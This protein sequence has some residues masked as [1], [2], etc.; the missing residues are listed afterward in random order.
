M[1]TTAEPNGT[2]SHLWALKVLSGVH[3]GAEA[4][5]ADEEATIGTDD[6]CDLILEESEV[7]ESHIRLAVSKDGVRLQLLNAHR[8]VY[9]DGQPIEDAI[10]VQ[11]F[12]VISMGVSSFALGPAGETWPQLAAAVAN[13]TA[14]HPP[15]QSTQETTDTAQVTRTSEPR[16]TPALR[17]RLAISIGLTGL[18]AVIATWLQMPTQIVPAGQKSAA[19]IERVMAIANRHGAVLKVQTPKEGGAGISLNGS[20][21][22][23]QNRQ[24]FLAELAQTGIQA[25][26]HI[27]STEEL[28]RIISPILD[29][30]LN[31]NRRNRVRAKPAMDAPGTLVVRG[32]VDK[33]A[34]LAAVKAILVRDTAAHARLRYNIET[35]ADRLAILQRYLDEIGLADQLHIQELEDGISLFGVAPTGDKMQELIELAREVN[36]Q[37]DSRPLLRLSGNDRFLGESTMKLNIRAVVLGDN[38]HVVMHDGE[39][40]TEGSTVENGYR[41]KMIEEDFIILEKSRQPASRAEGEDPALAYFI[42][43]RR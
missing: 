35:K 12:Q 7:G 21:D 34:D 13:G 43:N 22:T 29:Q 23:V 6:D 8:P 4:I 31:S 40:L 18:A 20:I 14:K 28:V 2:T 19:D 11:P 27:T 9:I 16:L 25:T 32:Y 37:F 41:L 33:E 26:A 3:A 15:T 5:L 10:D 39:R 1:T 24:R 30:T 38:K 42:L 36:E 17:K